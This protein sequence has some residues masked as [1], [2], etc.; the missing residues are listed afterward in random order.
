MTWNLVVLPLAAQDIRQAASYYQDV[1]PQ[2]VGPFLDHVQAV[3]DGFGYQ[4]HASTP[5]PNGLRRRSV[6]VFPYSIWADLDEAAE[7][8]AIVGVIHHKRNPR[9]IDERAAERRRP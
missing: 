5:H 8:I 3:I 2:Q 7:T 1:A 9:I 6:N 4:P